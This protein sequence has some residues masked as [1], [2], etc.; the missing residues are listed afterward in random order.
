MSKVEIYFTAVVVFSLFA[1]LAH[2]Y[3][4]SIYEVEYRISSRVLYLHSD[5]KIV[6]EAV[7]INSFGFRAPF[8]NSDTKFSLVEG[9]DLIEIVENNYEKGKLIIQSKNIPGVAIIR[10]KSKYSLLPTEFEIKIIPNLAW[11]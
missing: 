4:F 10:V 3:I 5:A 8:R 6:I 7:P 2:Q 1:F 9:N 11:L